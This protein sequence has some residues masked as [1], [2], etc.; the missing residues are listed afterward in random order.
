MTP[1]LELGATRMRYSKLNPW[2]I[3][4]V[5]RDLANPDTHPREKEINWNDSS[6]RA[7]LKNHE[8]WAMTEKHSVT[9]YP[10]I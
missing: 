3:M 1:T 2:P 7:W 9:K 6:D 4:V 5:T 8:H 10:L